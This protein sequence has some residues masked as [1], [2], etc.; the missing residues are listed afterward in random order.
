MNLQFVSFATLH[1]KKKKKKKKKRT[2]F[3]YKINKQFQGIKTPSN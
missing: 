2:A 1:H 3:Q